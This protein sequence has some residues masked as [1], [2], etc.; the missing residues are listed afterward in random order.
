MRNFHLKVAH[1]P[2]AGGKGEMRNFWG[3]RLGLD[4]EMRDPSGPKMAFSPEMRT[5]HLKCAHLSLSVGS[6]PAEMRDP[7][8]DFSGIFKHFRS[9][10]VAHFFGMAKFDEN[11]PFLEMRDLGSASPAGRDA[12]PQI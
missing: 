3:P 9:P 7:R 10:E 11:W 2:F 5:F 1:L 4:P 12:R 8:F 6:E